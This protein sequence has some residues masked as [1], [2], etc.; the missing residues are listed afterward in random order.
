MIIFLILLYILEANN[1]VIPFGCY[2]AVWIIT[3][4]QGLC[5]IVKGIVKAVNEVKGGEKK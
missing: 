1:I 3:V 5:G 2:I 4:L